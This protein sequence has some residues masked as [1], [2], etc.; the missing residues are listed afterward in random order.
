MCVS[1]IGSHVIGISRRV[2][3]DLHCETQVSSSIPC[4]R[5]DSLDLLTGPVVFPFSLFAC[6]V[7]TFYLLFALKILLLF[8]FVGF[9]PATMTVQVKILKMICN[10]LGTINIRMY[11]SYMYQH[12]AE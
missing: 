7:L 6:L 10:P 11:N 4:L 2:A 8:F 5:S 12:H 9:V 1:G 3:I